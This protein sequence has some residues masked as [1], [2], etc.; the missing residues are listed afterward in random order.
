MK[1]PREQGTKTWA[2]M[3][4]GTGGMSM[5]DRELKKAISEA[6]G[7]GQI[8]LRDGSGLYLRPM[9]G[10]WYW[11]YNYRVPGDNARKRKG[12]GSYPAVSM[13]QARKALSVFKVD[14]MQG[15]T[16]QVRKAAAEKQKLD[17]LTFREVA[18]EWMNTCTGD[19]SEDY[20]KQIASRLRKYV[21]PFFGEKPLSLVGKSDVLEAVKEEEK[22]SV[23]IAHKIAG[24]VGEVFKYGMQ[25]GII[26]ENP[27]KGVT[28]F[29]G[30]IPAKKHH[31]CILEPQRL[32]EVLRAIDAC[33]GGLSVIYCLKLLPYLFLRSK[34]LRCA[35]WEEFDL[36]RGLWVIPADKMKKRRGHIV[37]LA[38]SVVGMLADLK[39]RQLLKSPFLFPSNTKTGY[40]SSGGIRMALLRIGVMKTETVIHGFRG[41]ASTLLRE[42]GHFDSEL[43]ERQLAHVVGN[44]TELSYDHSERLEQRRSM[45]NWWADYLDALKAGNT[46]P[47]P[48]RA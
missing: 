35:K 33:N 2:I 24:F 7:A 44:S 48:F 4:H 38:P 31:P 36:D 17:G 21:F 13:A 9:A 46:P 30:R 3:E 39:N 43:V 45:L 37:P 25:K 12:F 20:R 41:T 8:Y 15:N 34:E 6:D 42:V 11:S 10:K 27:T 26:S 47:E 32:G 16:P 28:E 18:T 1:G 23:G 14:L 19:L 5:T 40:I 22:R 29:L